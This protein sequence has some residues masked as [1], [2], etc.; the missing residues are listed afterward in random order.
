MFV[1]DANKEELAIKEANVA[2]HS[3]RRDPRFE[4]LARRH[5]LPGSG[6]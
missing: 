2:G 1:I 3:G 6:E 5:R 4:R